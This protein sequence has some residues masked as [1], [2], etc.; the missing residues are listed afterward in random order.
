MARFCILD[1]FILSQGL[2]DNSVVSVSTVHDV[3]NLSDQEPLCL[4]LRLDVDRNKVFNRMPTDK[5][6]WYKANEIQLAAYR[7]ALA[8]NLA[9]IRCP[10]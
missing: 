9:A 6:A 4:V 1:H 10:L 3:D 5:I 7:E 2:F 8:A